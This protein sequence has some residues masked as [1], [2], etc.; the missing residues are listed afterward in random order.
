MHAGFTDQVASSIPSLAPDNQGRHIHILSD[1]QSALSGPFKVLW[2]YSKQKQ[3]K[4]TFFISIQPIQVT[5]FEV[6]N[7]PDLIS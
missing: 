6:I 1:V 4:N 2:T 5:D 3:L 7:I